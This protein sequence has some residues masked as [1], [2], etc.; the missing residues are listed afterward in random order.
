MFSVLRVC[1]KT[2]RSQRKTQS[3]AKLTIA[4]AAEAVGLAEFAVAGALCVVSFDRL[5]TAGA[6]RFGS[7]G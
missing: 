2:Q 3:S 1:F 7:A 4:D 6:R 5:Q